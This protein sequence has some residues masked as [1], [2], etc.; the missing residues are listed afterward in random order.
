MRLAIVNYDWDRGT[1]PW[2]EAMRGVG[3]DPVVVCVRSADTTVAHTHTRPSPGVIYRVRRNADL[4]HGSAAA[5]RPDVAHV[6]GLLHPALVTR[7]RKRLPAR[8]AIVV[9]DHGADPGAFTNSQRA[10]LR[11]A[12]A[13][14]DLLAV[15]SHARTTA[16]RES[17]LAPD[18]LAVAD[19]L[20]TSTGIQPMARDEARVRSG[21]D[22]SP[23]LLWVGGLTPEHDPVAVIRGFALVAGRFPTA[24]LTMVYGAADLDADV[25]AE[26]EKAPSL[27][28]R[29]R[30]VGAVPPAD[31]A[32]YYSA[33]DLFVVGGRALDGDGPL[34]EAMACGAVPVVADV[35]SFRTLSGS[36]RVGALWK[37]GQPQAFADALTRAIAKPLASERE[38]TRL[39]FEKQFSWPAI[40]WR[41]SELYGQ[42]IARRR[43]ATV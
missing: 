17:G 24:R 39:R 14:V 32:A 4:V 19:V 9:Q 7:L 26:I 27:G 21:I 6:N 5:A 30:L 29:V 37:P 42:A 12:L 36:E 11:R 1:P 2:A 34:L 40:A 22:G 20:E 23:A 43:G 15:A 3:C 31:L 33:A 10:S 16:W 18:R 41:A 28:L 25:R 35:P 8:S 38:A 13:V